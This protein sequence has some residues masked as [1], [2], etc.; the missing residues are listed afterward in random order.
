MIQLQYTAV[1]ADASGEVFV[2]CVAL[3]DS[4][5]HF[6]TVRSGP[7]QQRKKH[8][9]YGSYVLLWLRFADRHFTHWDLWSGRYCSLAPC[10]E[11]FG[12]SLYAYLTVKCYVLASVLVLSTNNNVIRMPVS[13]TFVAVCVNFSLRLLFTDTE[14]GSL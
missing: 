3:Y 8:G 6:V 7:R 2:R 13:V 11:L 5:E 14:S 4:L 9:D 12:L 10:F 1:I